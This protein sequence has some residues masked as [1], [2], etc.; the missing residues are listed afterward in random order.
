MHHIYNKMS[1][2]LRLFTYCFCVFRIVLLC[3]FVARLPFGHIVLRLTTIDSSMYYA[4]RRN[5]MSP[6][7]PIANAT[8]AK[9][10]DDDYR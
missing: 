5:F 9:C 10:D 2:R 3:Q 7:F 6:Q 4:F 1:I 8:A